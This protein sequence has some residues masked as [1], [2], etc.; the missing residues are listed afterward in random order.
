MESEF[1][2]TALG[3]HFTSDHI[4]R[5][6][7]RQISEHSCNFQSI[8]ALLDALVITPPTTTEN[9]ITTART[10]GRI[11][12]FLIYMLRLFYKKNFEK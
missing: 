12:S 8:E 6:L 4:R 3:M 5:V 7:E 10:T 9:S 11:Y 1:V 2:Q